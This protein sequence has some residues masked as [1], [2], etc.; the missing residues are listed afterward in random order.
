MWQ[1]EHFGITQINSKVAQE[2]IP[3]LIFGSLDRSNC[4]IHLRLP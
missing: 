1:F 4:H 3:E 2:A